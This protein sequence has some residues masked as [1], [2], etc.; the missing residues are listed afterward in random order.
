M[1]AEPLGVL[2]DEPAI[3]AGFKTEARAQEAA[4]TL[5]EL[6]P[7]GQGDEVLQR[8]LGVSIAPKA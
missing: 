2:S 8:M 7:S 4:D 6:E 5:N 3:L 1:I